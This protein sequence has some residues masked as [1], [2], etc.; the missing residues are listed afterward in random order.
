MVA[1]A[2][3]ALSSSGAYGAPSAAANVRVTKD[4]DTTYISADQLAGGSYTDTVL[5]RCGHDRRMQNEP[6]I[7]LDPRNPSVRTSGSNDY[8][9]IPNTG[10]AWAGFYVSKDSGVQGADR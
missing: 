2:A 1:A 8:C 7:A 10:D 4:A 6:T 5:Q 9:T 3:A